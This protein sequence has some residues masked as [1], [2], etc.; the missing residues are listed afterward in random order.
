M[1][2]REYK[3][4]RAFQKEKPMERFEEVVEQFTPMIH[5]VMRSLSIY[6]NIEEF[7][8]TGVIALWDAHQ[9]FDEDKGKFS[10]Y[11]YSYIR[12]RMMTELKQQRKEAER[13]VTPNEEFWDVV[14]D[15]NGQQPFQLEALL[16]HCDGLN[17]RQKQWVVYTFYYGMTVKEIADRE[18]VSLS[19]VKKWRAGA[20]GRIKGNVEGVG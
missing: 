17:D 15:E 2:T 16:S 8:Q 9:R 19:A 1:G 13:S 4:K 14:V 11:A 10:T 12:G 18:K 7:F 6:K 20:M 3:R 5:H